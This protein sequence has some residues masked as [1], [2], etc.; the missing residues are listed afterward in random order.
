MESAEPNNQVE[1]KSKDYRE[2]RKEYDNSILQSILIKMANAYCDP[3]GTG[4]LI[5]YDILQSLIGRSGTEPLRLFWKEKYEENM[6]RLLKFGVLVSSMNF[7]LFHL[8]NINVIRESNVGSPAFLKYREMFARCSLYLQLL[9][10]AFFVM[11][12]STDTLKFMS[13]PNEYISEARKRYE[14]IK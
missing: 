4:F 7:Y 5:E 13:I 1:N 3:L 9:H 8:N 14:N 10:E 11:L 6:E 12:D 2:L